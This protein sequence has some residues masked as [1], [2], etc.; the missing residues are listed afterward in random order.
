[1][2]KELV[3]KNDKKAKKVS[4]ST[5][6]FIFD[7]L[8]VICLVIFAII[9]SPKELQNDTFYTIKC[10]EYIFQNGIGNLTTDEFS[11]LDIPYCYPHW[12]YDLMIFIIY[13]KFG[14]DGIYISTIVFTVILGLLLYNTCLYV[15]KNRLVSSIISFLA[16]YI[17]SPYIAA[18][19]QLV[20][21]ILFAFEIYSIENF[22]KTKKIR[23]AIY[24]III[25]GLIAQLHVAVF[26]MFFIFILPY[27]AEFF[28]A[29]FIDANIDENIVKFL[30]KLIVK[31]SKKED[32]KKKFSAKINKV[33]QNIKVRKSRIEK[34]RENP[35]K[36]KTEKNKVIWLL[37]LIMIIAGFTGLLNPTGDTAYTYLYKTF[38]GNTTSSINEHLPTTLIESKNFAIAL[39][40][41]IVILTFMDLKIKLRDL[42]MLVGVTY[43]AFSSRRQLAIFAIAT[44]PILSKLIAEFFEKYDSKTCEKLLIKFTSIIGIILIIGGFGYFG[45]DSYKK[46]KNQEYINTSDYPVDACNWIKNNLDLSTLKI[47]N[48]YNYGA[49]LVY[50]GIPVFI[51]SRADLYS[52]EFNDVEG[53]A[54]AGDDIFSDALDIPSLSRGYEEIFE[55]YGVNH[56]MLYTNAKMCLLLDEDDNYNL[57]YDDDNFRVY[58][59]LNVNID[60]E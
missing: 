24:L 27:I 26:P 37:I 42:I 49:Y 40:V 33:E 53:F 35:Y 18:R 34:N 12:L 25:A 1:M 41:F 9:I 30:F 47:Y 5:R 20:T 31:F 58:E 46:N 57:L 36:V 15:S 59:R 4:I 16:L 8:F 3:K 45:Y 54:Q 17:L 22:I 14:L 43:M 6:E 55:K 11:W 21:F 44:A 39:L 56:V 23:Y 50:Q 28:I 60:G 10:G 32:T 48:E 2:D 38:K 51:D 29:M 13:A 7:I 19:A 52:P